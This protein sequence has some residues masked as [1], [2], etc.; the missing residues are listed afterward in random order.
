MV[1]SISK[2]SI[3]SL[4]QQYSQPSPLGFGQVLAP[5]MYRAEYTN[6]KWNKGALVPYEKILI[7]PAATSLQFAQQI[8][9]G[10]KAYLVKQESPHLF[11]PELNFNRLNRSAVRLSMPS[12]DADI[13]ADSIFQLTKALEEIIPGAP[14]QSLYLRPTVLGIDEQ[15]A[16]QGSE[17]F[18]Y[19]LMASPSDPYFA[20]A[21]KVLVER[22]HCRAA[23]GGTG[24]DKV[25]GNY[26]A[27]LNSTLKCREMGFDQP[28]WLDPVSR[29]NVEE[30]SGMNFFAM[31]DGRLV[32]PALSGSILPGVTRDSLIHLATHLGMEPVEKTMPIDALLKEIKIG[33]CT[34]AFASGTAA[35]VSPIAAIG[36]MGG[37]IYE[38][39]CTDDIANRLGTALLDIQEG[40]SNDEFGWMV[41]ASSQQELVKRFL[42]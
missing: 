41:D 21:I 37:E 36:E 25:G 24:A 8:F 20:Q 16:V 9:E 14:G 34:E 35:I 29:Q 17:D 19:L 2:T 30:L 5:V 42:R 13:F 22:E 18:T 10:M 4:V 31:I 28:L 23:V 26:A 11:R 33:D 6:G 39:P 1:D 12:M 3:D 27:S 40:R 32:T 15:F 7:S 38:L